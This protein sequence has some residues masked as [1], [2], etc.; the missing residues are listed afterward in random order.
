MGTRRGTTPDEVCRRP[1]LHGGRRRQWRCRVG[2]PAL[3]I[4]ALRHAQ[5]DGYPR[6]PDFLSPNYGFWRWCRRVGG[7]R[8]ARPSSAWS[9]RRSA[10]SA[11]S[12]GCTRR[13]GSRA[14]NGACEVSGRWAKH[15]ADAAARRGDGALTRAD[16]DCAVTNVGTAPGIREDQWRHFLGPS[17]GARRR[18][19]RA[20][21]CPRRADP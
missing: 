10:R 5:R 4:R 14:G 1:G 17:A 20:G 9:S 21:G 16:L 12:P 7:W 13:S 8:A 2:S 19:C 6:N 3:F 15:R 18:C 11:A